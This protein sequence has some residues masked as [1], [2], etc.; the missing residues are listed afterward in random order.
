MVAGASSLNRRAA[1]V[2][3]AHA[4]VVCCVSGLQLRDGAVVSS[5]LHTQ[6]VHEE[7]STDAACAGGRRFLSAH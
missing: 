1:R 4:G 3:D 2:L 6:V 7:P 5:L